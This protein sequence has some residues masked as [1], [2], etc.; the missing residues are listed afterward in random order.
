MAEPRLKPRFVWAL[1]STNMS[2]GGRD[3]SEVDIEKSE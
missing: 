1:E 2:E 3:G